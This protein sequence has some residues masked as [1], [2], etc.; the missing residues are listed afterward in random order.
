M[1]PKSLPKD[2]SCLCLIGSNQKWLGLPSKDVVIETLRR[3]QEKN[4]YVR[5]LSRFYKTPAFPAGSG[6]DFANVAIEILFK[7]ESDSLLE[8]FHSIEKE[9]GRKREKRWG[10]R[11]VDID[12][13]S[14]D[15]MVFPDVAVQTSWVNLPLAEQ[16]QKTPDRLIVP[17]PRMQDR[18]FVLGPLM[19]IAPDWCHPV[20]GQTVRQMFEALPEMDKATLEIL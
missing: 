3:F 11:T 13:I 8:I 19:D 5:S 4:L 6:P 9:M 15:T 7:G 17:H 16:M 2:V 10:E 20:T 12:L 14:F 1:S 18:A